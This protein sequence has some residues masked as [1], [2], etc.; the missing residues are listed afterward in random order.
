MNTM[1]TQS[2]YKPFQTSKVRVRSCMKHL[3]I[4]IYGW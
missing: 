4:K 2:T 1:I 3:Q